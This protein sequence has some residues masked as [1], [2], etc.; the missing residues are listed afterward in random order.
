MRIAAPDKGQRAREWPQKPTVRRSERAHLFMTLVRSSEAIPRATAASP[1]PCRRRPTASSGL[2]I[3]AA[4]PFH[5]GQLAHRNAQRA[6]PAAEGS[7]RHLAEDAPPPQS[8]KAGA[9][10]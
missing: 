9:A 10:A 5:A 4:P 6:C 2:S 1:L 8:P 7:Q 3:P